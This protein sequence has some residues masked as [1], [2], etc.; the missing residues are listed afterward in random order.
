MRTFY[1]D[2]KNNYK[3]GNIVIFLECCI[4]NYLNILDNRNE[5]E[6]ILDNEHYLI[7]DGELIL[8]PDS[9]LYVI[10]IKKNHKLIIQSIIM[11][12]SFLE[13]LINEIGSVELGSGY[14]K[15]NLDSLS[16]LAK[17]EIVLKLIYGKSLNKSENYYK[18][19]KNLVIARN[20]LVHYKSKVVDLK[21]M[22]P[23]DYYEKILFE[24]IKSLP[25]LLKDFEELNIK[26][27]T[28]S[29]IEI[30]SQFSRIK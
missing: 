20:S 1:H 12:C 10:L 11:L 19:Y 27:N 4:D 22:T 18:C 26:K 5:I 16:I 23:L 7:E 14:F 30:K 29:M 21:K 25:S 13:S 3:E 15:D 28:I 8:N 17:W 2:S 9:D 6:K 24:S